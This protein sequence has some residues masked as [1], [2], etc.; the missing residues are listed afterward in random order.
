MSAKAHL[1]NSELLVKD[2]RVQALGDVAG[3]FTSFFSD[4]SK[5]AWTLATN[6]GKVIDLPK[7]VDESWKVVGSES[8]DPTADNKIKIIRNIK[9]KSTSTIIL[10]R[11]LQ[12]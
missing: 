9:M 6:W 3:D 12:I 1:G 7:Q 10:Q 4:S 11:N 8:S 2:A 5:A